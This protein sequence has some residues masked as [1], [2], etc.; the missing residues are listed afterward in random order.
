VVLSYAPTASDGWGERT[1]IWNNAPAAGLV[2]GMGTVSDG[3]IGAW[4]D[5]DV[6][7]PV[8]GDT[9]GLATF[10]A[11]STAATNRGVTFSS[12]EGAPPPVLGITG[13][14]R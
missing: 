8:Q 7:A 13:T 2:F 14:R 1:I 9:D 11:T 5:V 4:I 10:V 3:M 6:T 12:R